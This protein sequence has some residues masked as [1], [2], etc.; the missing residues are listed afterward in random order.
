MPALP[1]T[2]ADLKSA[3]PDTSKTLR[4]KGLDAAIE[5]YRDRYGIPHVRAQ[6]AHDAFF[7]QGFVTAQDRLWHMDYDRLRAY[8]RW[9]EYAGKPG[10]EQDRLMRRFQIGP[11]VKGDYVALNAETRNMLD[12]YSAGVNAFV[13][14]TEM[15]PIEYSIVGARPEAWQPFDC[16]AVFKVRHV[17]M[18][19]YEGKLWRARLVK[20]IGPEKAAK[21]LRGYQPGHLVIVPPGA[22]YDG[23]IADGFKELS[24]GLK[25]IEY[26]RSGERAYAEDGDAGSNSWALA[27]SRTAS[28]KP[29]MAGDPHRPLD[30]PN[31]YYQNHIACPEFDAIGLSFPGCPGFPH[32]GHNA[33]AAWCVTHAGADYQDLYV[34]RFKDDDPT[35]Y[36]LKSRW[37]KAEVRHEVIEVRGEQPVEMDVTLTQ[38]GP[39]IAGDPSSGYGIAFKYTA[40]AE[41]NLGFECILEMLKAHSAD[42]LDEAMRKWVDP[43]NNFLCADVHGNI[44]YLNRGK[45]PIRSASNAWL[46]VPGWTGEHEWQGYIPFE[47]LARSRNPDTGYIVTANN[48]IVGTDYPYYIALDFAP[49]YRARRI[50]ERVKSMTRATVEDMASVHAERVSIPAQTFV[51]LLADVQPLDELS[52]RAKA[53][54]AGWNGSMER[55]S[56]AP[57]IYSAFRLRLER[58]VIEGLLGDLTDEAYKA[59][60]RGAPSHL[61]QL[62]SWLVTMAREND[63]TYLPPGSDWRSLLAKALSDGVADL[64]KRLGDNI[65]AWQWGRVHFTRPKH[66]LSASFPELAPLLDPPSVPMGGDGD[67]PQ[68]GSYSPA[69]PFVM[70]GMSVA[71]YVFDAADWDNS[72]WIVPLGVSGHPAS[73]HYADQSPIWGE[74]KLVPM[75]YD[76]A[77]IKAGAESRQRLE[78]A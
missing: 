26:G 56:V 58:T 62:G 53:K 42:E 9:A 32:F 6:S 38:H 43:C 64:R 8:G 69:E 19:V 63:T 66:T 10:L 21:L 72:R 78:K 75:L 23:P 41:P 33:H 17:L 65:D 36:M 31:V 34:E 51:K 27:G 4:L 2:K 50:V 18:G 22:E 44:G 11:T 5:I 60:G 16:L 77:R 55:D 76:W 45:V 12:A 24:E 67:T 68:A 13:E 46:P 29:L 57:T 48:R 3:L 52:A 61:R 15:L 20:T 49:E 59:T 39:V 47:K 7:G 14:T 25:A 37:R 70:T 30:T 71:R 54:L 28:G 1:K 35:R 40:T 74:L 73:P